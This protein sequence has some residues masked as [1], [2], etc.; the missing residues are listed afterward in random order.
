MELGLAG[1][2]YRVQGH[3]VSIGFLGCKS[4][5]AAAY[6]DL[7]GALAALAL[8]L[9]LGARCLDAFWFVAGSPA[10]LGAAELLP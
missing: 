4:C 5:K 3:G 2:V 1:F 10:P 7:V 8:A 6:F 9:A